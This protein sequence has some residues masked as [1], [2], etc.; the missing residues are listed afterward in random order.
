[1]EMLGRTV[2]IVYGVLMLVGGFMGHRAGSRASLIAGSISGVALLLAAFV[3]TTNAPAGLWA[4]AAISLVLAV[5]FA[6][7]TAVTRKLMPSGMLLAVSV[8]A[9]ALLLYAALQLPS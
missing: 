6:R 4:G 1:M 8:V 7:R 2:L 5:V 9:L 3:S